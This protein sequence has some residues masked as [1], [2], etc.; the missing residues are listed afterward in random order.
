MQYHDWMI[1]K[2]DEVIFD[3]N[4]GGVPHQHCMDILISENVMHKE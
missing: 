2:M 1:H 4:S 3:C